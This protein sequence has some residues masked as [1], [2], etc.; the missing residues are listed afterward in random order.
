MPQIE[1][2]AAF[3]SS[4]IF[5]LLVFFGTT[6]FII[7]RMMVPRVMDTVQ[8]RDRQ[9]GDDLKAA[10]AARDKAD[11]EEEAWR[12]REN[13]NRAAAQALIAEAKAD[14]AARN[15]RRV[16]GAQA[17]IDEQI[18]NAEAEIAAARQSAVSKIEDVAADATQDIV[19][20]LAAIDI[21]E[22]QARN[23]VKGAMAHG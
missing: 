2:L 21:S 15:E 5:W 18:A 3:Y 19:A 13:E 17:E 12:H 6:F 1:Q 4:Q 10:Q 20:R 16:K 7:G 22:A 11:A 9:I 23:A 14:A 8:L